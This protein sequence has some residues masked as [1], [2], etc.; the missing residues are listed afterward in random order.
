MT[1]LNRYLEICIKLCSINVCSM[2]FLACVLV[3]PVRYGSYK[4]K[5]KI[6]CSQPV[7]DLLIFYDIFENR[8]FLD[9]SGFIFEYDDSMITCSSKR[10]SKL[11]AHSTNLAILYVSIGVVSLQ[12]SIQCKQMEKAGKGRKLISVL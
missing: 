10:P 1:K 6:T 7:A 4:K 8:F 11:L 12:I 5:M 3:V 9:F 2:F